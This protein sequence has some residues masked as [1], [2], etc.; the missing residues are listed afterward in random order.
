MLSL[1]A[2]AAGR[3]TSELHGA[4]KGQDKGVSSKP[5][6]TNT[7]VQNNIRGTT[8]RLEQSMLGTENPNHISWFMQFSAVDTGMYWTSESDVL[9]LRIWICVSAGGTKGW[10]TTAPSHWKV[11]VL[12][13]LA[14]S[15]KKKKPIA[16]ESTMTHDAPPP[17]HPHSYRKTSPS[18]RTKCSPKVKEQKYW[19]IKEKGGRDDKLS[20][21]SHQVEGLLAYEGTETQ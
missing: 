6:E 13:C 19:G 12:I 2:D 1:N 20:P 9:S 8:K 14:F 7:K 11:S 5:T 16:A 17:P 18:C 3:A 15:E 21:L 4:S 10:M